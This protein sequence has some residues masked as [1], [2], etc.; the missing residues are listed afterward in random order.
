[1]IMDN[2]SMKE[3]RKKFKTKEEQRNFFKE[4]SK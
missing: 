1:M 3:I 2:Y 4:N